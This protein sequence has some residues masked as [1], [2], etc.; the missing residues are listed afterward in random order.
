M[1]Y[2][3]LS[4]NQRQSMMT[5]ERAN[6]VMWS[7]RTR[8]ENTDPISVPEQYRENQ[9]SAEEEIPTDDEPVGSP[10]SM[11][12][13]LENLRTDQ[14]Q[15]LQVRDGWKPAN[16]KMQSWQFSK[17]QAEQSPKVCPCVWLWKFEMCA[18]VSTDGTAIVA[19]MNEQTGFVRMLKT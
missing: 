14:M 13:L 7:H 11:T 15:R 5:P 4:R 10:G 3:L 16:C 9:E 6:F 1:R 19:V 8:A 17:L 18:S 12:T 2:S